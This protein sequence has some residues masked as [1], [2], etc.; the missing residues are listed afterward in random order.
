MSCRFFLG[1]DVVAALLITKRTSAD[2]GV[3]VK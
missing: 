2:G 3:P 1:F